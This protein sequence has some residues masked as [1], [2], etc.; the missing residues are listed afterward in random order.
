MTPAPAADPV[1]AAAAVRCWIAN[2]S[3]KPSL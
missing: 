1:V 3:T 2:G